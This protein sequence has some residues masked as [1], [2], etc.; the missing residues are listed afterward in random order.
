M[1]IPGSLPF[2]MFQRL[3]TR[4]CISSVILFSQYYKGRKYSFN[5]LKGVGI[6]KESKHSH[7]YNL[8]VNFQTV[9]MIPEI[10]LLK[11]FIFI[12]CVFY[13]MCLS[14]VA[15]E[16]AGCVPAGI[17]APQLFTP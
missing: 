13:S 6:K 2:E 16:V 4:V 17:P 9:K 14:I 5:I 7:S 1:N 12:S 11:T 3:S 10:K 8:T 15:N